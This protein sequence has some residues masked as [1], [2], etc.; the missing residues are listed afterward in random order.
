MSQS[1]NPCLSCGVC[2]M[3]YRVAFH[4][5]ET[6]AHPYG[7]VPVE[8]TEPLRRHEVVM[9][10]TMNPPVRCIALT[11]TPGEAVSCAIHGTHPE[12]CREVALGEDQCRRAREM[13]GLPP[14]R[15]LAIARAYA[16]V[17]PPAL[18]LAT[19][20][21]SEL[22][23]AESAAEPVA[24]SGVS[25][26]IARAAAAREQA[27]QQIIVPGAE[28]SIDTESSFA[29]DT[30]RPPDI[31]TNRMTHPLA[32]AN[33]GGPHDLQIEVDADPQRASHADGDDD[34]GDIG[35]LRRQ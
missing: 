3:S 35:G 12:C 34:C 33:M 29:A 7:R 2:C 9:R 22:A 19:L 16:C 30:L 32:G 8:L 21:D 15:P 4:W 13:H 20:P 25:S 10:G 26:R 5:S 24:E 23:P 28:S 11:G 14:L 18:P 31:H 6:T 17:D 27:P 1:G